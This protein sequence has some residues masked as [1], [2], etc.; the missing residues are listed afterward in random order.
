MGLNNLS[1]EEIR[2]KTDRRDFTMFII[3]AI[4]T[5]VLGVEEGIIVG[6]EFQ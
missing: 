3:T 2:T 1:S 4:A 6:S 5:L